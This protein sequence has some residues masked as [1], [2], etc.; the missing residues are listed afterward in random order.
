MCV[1]DE[2]VCV[3]VQYE[4]HVKFLECV[5]LLGHRFFNCSYYP[6]PKSPKCTC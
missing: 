3:L 4:W 1:E 5:I 6:I 2:I